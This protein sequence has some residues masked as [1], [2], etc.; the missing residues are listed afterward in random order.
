MKTG[1]VVKVVRSFGS[2]WGRIRPDGE[3]RE[4]FFNRASLAQ[5][6]DFATMHEGEAVEFAE[7]ED[8]ASG[9]RAIQVDRPGRLS[10]P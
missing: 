7:R 2:E 3:L 5:P 4:L 6:A 9:S 8:G 1:V 10:A